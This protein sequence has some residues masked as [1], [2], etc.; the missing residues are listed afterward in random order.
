MGEQYGTAQIVQGRP[1]GGRPSPS[2]PSHTAPAHQLGRT[3]QMDPPE[4]GNSGG[5][6]LVKIL[7]RMP[8]L[9]GMTSRGY[10]SRF[11]CTLTNVRLLCL[12]CRSCA[13]ALHLQS[14]V[15]CRGVIS[16]LTVLLSAP[17]VN[18]PTSPKATSQGCAL[19]EGLP[20]ALLASACS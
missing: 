2:G 12:S 15:T 19:L 9:V 5:Y 13:I 4:P 14:A 8:Q 7:G 3:R 20:A 10:H 16:A 18:A 11:P 1:G 6:H 17:A